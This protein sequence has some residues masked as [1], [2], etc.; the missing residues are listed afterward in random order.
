MSKVNVTAKNQVQLQE[1]VDKLKEAG[2]PYQFQKNLTLLVFATDAQQV[3]GVKGKTPNRWYHY[4]IAIGLLIAF[5]WL[6]PSWCTRAL[7]SVPERTK[8]EKLNAQFMPGSNENL[9]LA[10]YIKK[11]MFDPD[12]YGHVET[13]WQMTKDTL[14][15]VMTAI[16]GKNQLGGM[17]IQRAKALIDADGNVLEFKWIE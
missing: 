2:K 5:L 9:K 3:L 17:T 1:W 6:I 16:R 8:I 12:S 11:I 14:A 15:E 4:V 13:S 10:R 7:E